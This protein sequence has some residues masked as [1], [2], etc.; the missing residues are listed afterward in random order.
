M[1][2]DDSGPA[3]PLPF[4]YDEGLGRYM[5]GDDCGVPI[6]MSMRQY[7]AIHL[8]VP[9]SG[10]DWLDEMIREA[11]G[12]ATRPARDE[13]SSA[14]QENPWLNGP[15]SAPDYYDGEWQKWSGGDCPV[16]PHA[17]VRI[18]YLDGFQPCEPRIAGQLEWRHA[19]RR[20]DIIRFR[21]VKP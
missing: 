12:E 19:G 21:V 17:R 10:L 20:Y 18:I 3:F 6:G 1:S 14:N 4:I 15:P 9:N 13:I 8:K 7:A 5:D 11:R 2:T 16:P